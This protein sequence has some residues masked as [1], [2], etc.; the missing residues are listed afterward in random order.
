[1]VSSCLR[2]VANARMPP[3]ATGTNWSPFSKPARQRLYHRASCHTGRDADRPG[4]SMHYAWIALPAPRSRASRR[5]DT[6]VTVMYEEQC[7]NRCRVAASVL[8]FSA[9]TAPEK[10]SESRRIQV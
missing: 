4:Q 7:S 6:C 5:S 10:I 8:E 3:L 9:T 2:G 1:M